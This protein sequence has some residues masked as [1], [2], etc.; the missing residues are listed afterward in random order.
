MIRRK[1]AIGAT[2][3]AVGAAISLPLTISQG[4]TIDV[5]VGSTPTPVSTPTPDPCASFDFCDEFNDSTVDTTK[6]VVMNEHADETNS[7]PACYLPGQTVETGGYLTETA[8]KQTSTSCPTGT[9]PV[10][11]VSGAV[12]TKTYKWKYGTLEVRAKVAGGQ[13]LWPA[14]WMLGEDCQAPTWLSTTGCDW[15]EIGSEEVDFVEYL[16]GNFTNPQFNL[17]SS[18][19]GGS[20]ACGPITRG[21]QN[22]HTYKL[23]WTE[24]MMR[25]SI[26]GSVCHTYTSPTTHIPATPMFLIMNTS[27]GG[28]GGGSITDGNLPQTTYVDYVRVTE[29]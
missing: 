29:A 8:K 21:D 6:W 11:Y 16:S 17:H 22:F 19:G 27:L 26:D 12:Q 7:E 23:E 9:S 4:G 18:A 1:L 28:T 25:D 10:S 3:V 24:T 20:F 2:I 14:I 13:G 15:P 5:F